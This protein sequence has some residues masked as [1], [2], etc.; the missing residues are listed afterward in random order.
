MQLARLQ[1]RMTDH[2]R[3][4]GSATTRRKIVKRSQVDPLGGQCRSYF[5]VA[6][7]PYLL[8]TFISIHGLQSAI[9]AWVTRKFAEARR[10]CFEG[11]DQPD[12]ADPFGMRQSRRRLSVEAAVIHQSCREMSQ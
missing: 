7:R 5:G 6:E 9:H 10:N 3:S 12:H 8:G 2:I 4:S 1:G 11:L